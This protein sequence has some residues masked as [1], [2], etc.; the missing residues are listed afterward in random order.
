MNLNYL[1]VIIFNLCLS[2]F[3][4]PLPDEASIQFDEETVA[5]SIAQEVDSASAASGTISIEKT[6]EVRVF[7]CVCG[8]DK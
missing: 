7:M 8:N 6:I 4:L 5:A 3:C 1:V 2:V